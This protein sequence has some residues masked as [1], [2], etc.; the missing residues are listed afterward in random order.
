MEDILIGYYYTSHNAP[1]SV[2]NLCCL[3]QNTSDTVPLVL[4]HVGLGGAAA[5]S[6]NRAPIL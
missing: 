4:R 5:V 1:K 6:A 3:K 2:P